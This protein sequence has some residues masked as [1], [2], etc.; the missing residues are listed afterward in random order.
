MIAHQTW[1][2]DKNNYEDCTFQIRELK[3]VNEELE[4]E[5]IKKT[6]GY[7]IAVARDAFDNF[8]RVF[9]KQTGLVWVCNTLKVKMRW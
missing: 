8:V 6:F 1:F 5:L 4:I 9:C 7:R 2:K 3:R